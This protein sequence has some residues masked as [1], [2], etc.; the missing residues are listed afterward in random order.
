M[1]YQY[2]PNG[3]IYPYANLVYKT[4]TQVWTS[5]TSKVN[6]VTT[7]S[8]APV[9]PWP[10]VTHWFYSSYLTNNQPPS[11]GEI[12]AQLTTPEDIPSVT[13][14]AAQAGGNISGK[15]T[16]N[17]VPIPLV[18]TTCPSTT[19]VLG[20]QVPN[21]LY[22]TT[23]YLSS[24]NDNCSLY[25]TQSSTAGTATPNAS[26]TGSCFDPANTPGQAYAALS[27][28]AYGSYIYTFFWN[29]MGGAVYDDDNYANGIVQISCASAAHVLLIQ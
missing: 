17:A 20:L 28:Q 13:Q 5:S 29:D 6:G 26:Y 11:E 18:A 27:C 14:D 15:S 3:C 25:I 4:V 2:A 23:T 7:T 21:D 12:A 19:T 1:L 24:G 9:L 8:Y 16:Y 10:K 22:E